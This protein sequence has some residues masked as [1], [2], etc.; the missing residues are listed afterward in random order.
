[1]KNVL[2]ALALGLVVSA[3][4]PTVGC[5]GTD[6]E[7]GEEQDQTA[8]AGKFETFVGRDG[9]HYFQLVAGNGARV[10]RSEGYTTLSSAKKGISSVKS[11][12]ATA[13]NYKL[14][15]AKNGEYYFNLVAQNHEI[16]GT[17]EAY[18][19]KGNAERALDAVSKMIA[20]ATSGEAKTG[21]PKLETF[22]GLDGQYYFRLR[23]SNGEL[24]L[25]SEGYTTKA[26]AENGAE[27]VKA[28]GVDMARYDIVEA[29]NGQHY[30]RVLATN[31]QIIGRGELYV[32]AS[33]AERGARAVRS[34]LRDLGDRPATDKQ[35]QAELEQAAQDAIYVS[36]SD[37]GFQYVYASLDGADSTVTEKLVR[38]KLAKYV[39]NDS[40]VD[41]P[42]SELYAM[43]GS[44]E[45]WKSDFSNCDEDSYP[46]PHECA[47]LQEM[48]EGLELN[49]HGIKIFYFG[50]NGEPGSV[51]GVAVSVFLVG[52]TPAGNLAGFRTVAI[53]T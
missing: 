38:S 24:V 40:N 32:S 33:N 13:G 45:E 53:W 12:G 1:M 4:V 19:S 29:Q 6:A 20:K 18:A 11:N 16:I 8:S 7:T 5:G 51:D 2:R 23:A 44:L 52:R 26:K 36:E 28:N 37:E 43:S 10:L 25:Q 49:L 17:S 14:L 27:S 30:F 35:V 21:S 31:G 41:G 3:V 50:S 34:I 48:L 46:G 9:L 39:D 22:T 47:E 42:M 15:K